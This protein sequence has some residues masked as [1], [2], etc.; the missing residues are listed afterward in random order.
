MIFLFFLVWILF[1]SWA[2][3]FLAPSR[4]DRQHSLESRDTTNWLPQSSSP[5]FLLSSKSTFLKSLIPFKLFASNHPFKFHWSHR[6][7]ILH[8]RSASVSN[9][10]T[11]SI[12]SMVVW[13]SSRCSGF[14][15]TPPSPKR[16][17]TWMVCWWCYQSAHRR[18]C[19]A[20]S[21]PIRLFPT[22]RIC[23]TVRDPLRLQ[24]YKSLS[25]RH[26]CCARVPLAN[27]PPT[28]CSI[29]T[30]HSPFEPRLPTPLWSS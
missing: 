14:P 1:W 26:L 10:A 27:T 12:T 8:N 17:S 15:T 18:L 6:Y 2:P 5:L 9:H 30:N 13:W 3:S 11:P 24:H 16:D 28:N 19:H 29:F 21:T 7:S 20:V 23:W 22:I 4:L 25:S